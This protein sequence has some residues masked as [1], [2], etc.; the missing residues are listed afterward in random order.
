MFAREQ[1]ASDLGVN[2]DDAMGMLTSTGSS[3]SAATSQL[4]AGDL[5]KVTGG[6]MHDDKDEQGD[7]GVSGK[8][9]KDEDLISFSHHVDDSALDPDDDNDYVAQE[10]DDDMDVIA[11]ASM[12]AL[13]QYAMFLQTGVDEEK[14]A[15][16]N[17]NEVSALDDGADDDADDVEAST[18]SG[19]GDQ[20]TR[21]SSTKSELFALIRKFDSLLD[22]VESSVVSLCYRQQDAEEDLAVVKEIR[23]SL[24]PLRLGAVSLLLRRLGDAVMMTEDD[25]DVV[26]GSNDGMMIMRWWKAGGQLAKNRN[27]VL[28]STMTGLQNAMQVG[29]AV[30]IWIV[31]ERACGCCLYWL[32]IHQH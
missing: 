15:P 6:I 12:S 16:G 30:G 7:M 21:P 20:N 32:H 19:E 17:N 31:I 4:D 3:N 1:E 23:A 14:I 18:A 13:E 9:D 11:E 25:A 10:D 26:P 27:K 24:L 8:D 5:D 2:D 29:W 28:D 22:Q